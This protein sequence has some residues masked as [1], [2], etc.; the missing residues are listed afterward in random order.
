[1]WNSVLPIVSL[2]KLN[3]TDLG[4]IANSRVIGDATKAMK[5]VVTIA[6][7]LSSGSL[8]LCLISGFSPWVTAIRDV[9]AIVRIA[10]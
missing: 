1:M 3:E 8:N 10:K 4:Q 6:D 7:G 5:N 2:S 9:I